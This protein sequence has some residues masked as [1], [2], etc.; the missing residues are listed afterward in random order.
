MLALAQG[1]RC[2][3]VRRR[4]SGLLAWLGLALMTATARAEQPPPGRELEIPVLVVD[5]AGVDDLELPAAL[6]ELCS[7]VGIRVV[8]PFEAVRGDVVLLAHIRADGDVLQLSVEDAETRRQIG[9]RTVPRAESQAIARETLAH[10]LLGLVEPWIERR[11]REQ[12][13]AAARPQDL[14]STPS[15][16]SAPL[17]V[18]LGV[19][20]GPIV[21][22]REQWG[23]R[24]YGHTGF[25]WLRKS[26]PTVAVDVSGALPVPVEA[27]AVSARFWLV[28]A[29]LR[30]RFSAFSGPRGAFDVALSG[31]ADLLGLKPV[32]APPGT[33][34]ESLSLR[35]QGVFGAALTGRVH[36]PRRIDLV[37]GAGLDVDLKPRTW[38]I[39]A[40][41]METTLLS[42]GYLR[43]YA[44]VGVD[45][46]LRPP[47]AEGQVAP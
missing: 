41:G 15:A 17:D 25:T 42:T 24:V 38:A 16:P 6:R 12:A 31:G 46:A 3:S 36:L 4:R 26:A 18:R 45:F 28:G 14:P 44:L 21:L 7:R 27:A 2:K 20:A 43:P 10:V 34:L 40:Y 9:E 29:R 37:F 33:R 22:A 32:S 13:E 5:S 39:E 30:G 47:P 11:R 19:G 23:A 1:S 8:A 35:V